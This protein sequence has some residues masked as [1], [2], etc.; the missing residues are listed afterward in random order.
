MKIEQRSKAAN[1]ELI[2]YLDKYLVN[3]PLNFR[4]DVLY[5][6]RLAAPL[7]ERTSLVRLAADMAGVGWSVVKPFAFAAEFFMISALT[8]DDVIDGADQRSGEP[9]LFKLKGESRSFLIAEWLHAMANGCLSQKHPTAND[10]Q[11]REAVME[12]RSAY[13]FLIMN[14]YVE[15]DEEGNPDVTL[16]KIDELAEGRTGGLLKVCLTVPAT[17]AG[18]ADLKTNLD[19]CGRWLGIA[20]QHRDD[21]LDFICSPE[22]IGKPVLLDLLNGQPNIVLSHALTISTDQ[23]ARE[24]ILK[25]FGAGLTNKGILEHGRDMQEDVLSTLR[26]CGSLE[27]ASQVVRDYCSRAGD[28]LSGV[29]ASR[30]KNELRNIIDLVSEIEFPWE[31]L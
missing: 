10:A 2:E 6:I 13:S 8:A 23:T 9:S 1:L 5:A 31:N 25:Y 3:S 26:K 22:V 19:D 28:A 29:P 11:W 24:I 27:Y 16:E 21:I 12:F 20:F 30:A 14:Q 17:I 15:S 18:L 4:N 7:R